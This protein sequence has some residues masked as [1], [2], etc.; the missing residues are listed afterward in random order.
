[1][2]GGGAGG[3]ELGGGGAGGGGAELSFTATLDTS[4]LGSWR[5]AWRQEAAQCGRGL[6]GAHS[7]GWGYLLPHKKDGRLGRVGGVTIGKD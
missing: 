2:G 3:A 5:G 4:P 1:M 7:L 6:G